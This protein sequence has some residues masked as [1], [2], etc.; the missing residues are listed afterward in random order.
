MVV[1]FLRIS[2][3]KMKKYILSILFAA[4]AVTVHAQRSATS[5][6]TAEEFEKYWQIESESADC[7]HQFYGDTLELVSPKGLTLWRKQKMRGRVT[8]EY[9]ACVMTDRPGDRLSD[10]NCFWMASDPMYPDDIMARAPWRSGIFVRCYTLQLYYV[11]YGGNS[12]STTRFRRYAGGEAGVEDASQRPPVLKEYT[13]AA[14][15]LRPGHWYH[16]KIVC[17]GKHVR[18]YVDGE[19]LV[20]YVDEHPLREGWFGFR[21]T[22]SRTRLTHFRVR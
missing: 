7:S 17:R 1:R 8:I 16:I 13:D 19:C 14:H 15:L 22:L 9:D 20:D 10:L 4:A 5:G 3:K 18:Y 12:N 11:G 6:L 21:T 2:D